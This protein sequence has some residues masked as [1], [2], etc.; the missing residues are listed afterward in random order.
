MSKKLIILLVLIG[1]C[2]VCLFAESDGT[3]IVQKATGK[4]EYEVSPGKWVPVT[5]GMKLLC[6]SMVN[7]GLNSSLVL[8]SD[9]DVVTI[10]PMKKGT[11]EKL[12]GKSSAARLTRGA[13]VIDSDI[14]SSV[15]KSTVNISTAASRASEAKEDLEWAE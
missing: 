7:T 1:L 15:N 4:V 2:S 8:R 6:S 11:I 9:A 5:S 10:K 3:Y 12:V 14:N 13:N